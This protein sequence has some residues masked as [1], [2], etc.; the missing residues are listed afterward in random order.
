[1]AGRTAGD[2]TGM[3]RAG[4]GMREKP[5]SGMDGRER[6]VGVEDGDG[7][8]RMGKAIVRDGKGRAGK[9][10]PNRRAGD[11]RKRPSSRWERRDGKWET[12]YGL[13]ERPGRG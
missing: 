13:G 7:P 4:M 3:G 1:M 6:K 5:G 10:M 11:G 9:E 2:E 12:I 8:V